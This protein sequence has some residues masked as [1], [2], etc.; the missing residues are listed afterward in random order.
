MVGDSASVTRS[1]LVER[2]VS[3]RVQV[4]NDLDRAR[5]LAIQARGQIFDIEL[6]PGEMRW[7]D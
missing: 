7:F 1:G 2:L 3:G 4:R 6:Q 5:V